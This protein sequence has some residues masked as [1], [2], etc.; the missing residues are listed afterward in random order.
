LSAVPHIFGTVTAE[1]KRAREPKGRP[2]SPEE[3]ARLLDAARSRHMLIFLLIA[4]NTLAR[5]AAILDLGPAQ[6]DEAHDLLDLNPP[7][8][9]QNKKYRP[10]VQVTPTLLP[11]LRREVGPSGRYISYRNKGS[12]SILH[13]W[14]LTRAQAGLDKRVTPYSIRHGLARE[15]RKRRVPTEQ[16]S[17]FLGHLPDGSAATTSIYAPYEP[18]FLAD[19]VIRRA[20]VTP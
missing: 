2:V 7:G 18:G 9:T 5:P 14:R 11:W 20:I 8:R 3:I 13:M 19:A 12:R 4:A 17:L 15:M 6:F 1:A 16:I 10:I